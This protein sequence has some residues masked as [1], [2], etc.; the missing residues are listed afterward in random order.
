MNVNSF[1]GSL[2]L[3]YVNDD[4]VRRTIYR[5]LLACYMRFSYLKLKLDSVS[6]SSF[7]TDLF[8][9]AFPYDERVVCAY[10]S[11]FR[12]KRKIGTDD[13]KSC[14][15]VNAVFLEDAD[16]GVEEPLLEGEFL[17]SFRA[18]ENM[19]L[20]SNKFSENGVAGAVCA[21]HGMPL[22]FLSIG[23]TGESFEY[24]R[25]K[26]YCGGVWKFR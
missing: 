18:I 13:D 25:S 20:K 2:C 3:P 1:V 24:G 14:S 8:C 21:H 16:V 6:E 11:C 22:S 19:H 9:P 7:L 12:L 5:S 4:L 26:I 10:D 17:S 15:L 23:Q